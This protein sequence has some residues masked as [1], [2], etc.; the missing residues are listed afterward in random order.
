MFTFCIAAMEDKLRNNLLK[1]PSVHLVSVIE[2]LIAEF[3][4]EAAAIAAEKLRTLK[5]C[6]IVKLTPDTFSAISS[7]WLNLSEFCR[8]DSAFCHRNLRLQ[9]KQCVQQNCIVFA[10]PTAS[11]LKM[12]LF[13]RWIISR[14]IRLDRLNL[15]YREIDAELLILYLKASGDSLRSIDFAGA[16]YLNE[17]CVGTIIKYCPTLE[18]L[19]CWY[20]NH[21]AVEFVVSI[22]SHCTALRE[23]D[24]SYATANVLGGLWSD[25]EGTCIKTT[26]LRKLYLTD[27]RHL[28]DVH[29]CPIVSTCTS[30][31]ELSLINCTNLTRVSFDA[32]ATNLLQLTSLHT[33][34]TSI[35]DTALIQIV[36]NCT[37]LECLLLNDCVGVTQLSLT[38]ILNHSHHLTHL[39]LNH[40]PHVADIFLENIHASFPKLTKFH[41]D[42]CHTVTPTGVLCVVKNCALLSVF[43]VKEFHPGF[44]DAVRQGI[45]A[46]K[47]WLGAWKDRKLSLYL[48]TV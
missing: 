29:F 7:Q 32:V 25:F 27:Q 5:Q 37:N 22:F 21:I 48:S 41:I 33:C 18:V 6:W 36:Q 19:S 31:A 11:N 43:S 26:A 2:S 47:H 44:D 13:V 20:C 15:H 34:S 46:G 42:G 24:L 39:S 14:Q 12:E 28:C 4:E 35:H 23:L 45:I 10:Q 9:F 38:A 17:E 40:N 1:L 16:N 30:L 8:L 3:G